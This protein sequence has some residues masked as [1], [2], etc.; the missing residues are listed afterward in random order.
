MSRMKSLFVASLVFGMAS[1]SAGALSRDFQTGDRTG[2]YSLNELTQI[3]RV[4]I[5]EFGRDAI[6]A[7]IQLD[8]AAYSRRMLELNSAFATPT[9]EREEAQGV[10]GNSKAQRV[11]EVGR[12]TTKLNDAPPKV[13]YPIETSQYAVGWTAEYLLTATPAQM[14]LMTI[15]AERAMLQEH[16]AGIRAALLNPV[17]YTHNGYV[18]DKTTTD[19]K[20]LFNNDGQVPERSPSLNTFDGT[21]SHYLASATLTVPA[22]TALIT[23]I[24]EHT[25]NAQLVIYINTGDAYAW[26][27]L[28]GFAPFIDARVTS[29][30]TVTVANG[31]LDFANQAERDI[32]YFLGAVVRTR[33]WMPVGYALCLDAGASNKVLRMRQPRQAARQG[34]RMYSDVMI[35]PL[36]AEFFVE[37]FGY[38]VYNRGAAAVLQY[39]SGTYTVPAGL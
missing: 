1:A 35:F 11:D 32:G 34:L 10:T 6:L 21:H 24:A 20:A 26:T 39:T 14:A 38:G 31:G 15:D 17:N 13:G 7:S 5:N 28:A 29:A 8:L 33:G 4:T 18:D 30:T 16:I 36:Q 19:V 9:T 3:T 12:V 25:V 37:Q 23:T 27:Q 22:I 2:T